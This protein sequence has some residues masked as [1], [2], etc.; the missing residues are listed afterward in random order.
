MPPHHS[1]DLEPRR[2][3]VRWRIVGKEC[4]QRV[5]PAAIAEHATVVIEGDVS[6]PLGFSCA[7]GEMMVRVE[8]EPVKILESVVVALGQHP[9]SPVHRE[10][11]RVD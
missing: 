7:E 11:L 4:W 10:L 2:A 8:V 6:V 3:R 5:S 1:R 9:F